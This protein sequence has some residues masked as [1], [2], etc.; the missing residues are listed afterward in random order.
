[1]IVTYEGEHNHPLP[2]AARAMASTTSAAATMLLSG[3]ARSADGGGPMNL[4]VLSTS[5]FLPTISTLAPIPTITLDL[6][7]PMAT[8]QTTPQPPLLPQGIV[9]AAAA[10]LTR[11]PSFTAAL[12]SA[13]T[14][15]IGGNN[16]QLNSADLS[17][18]DVKPSPSI[19]SNVQAK[20]L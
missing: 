7:N 15:I 3:A 9:S 20:V 4:G 17:D 11:N 19:E 2:A 14:S 10:A 12:V 13:I 16:A 18:Q 8:Q 5:N 1:M 6:T